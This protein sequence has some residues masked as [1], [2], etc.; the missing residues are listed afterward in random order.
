MGNKVTYTSEDHL[1]T[2]QARAEEAFLA[3]F[4]KGDYTIDNPYV[5]EN[6]YLINPLCAMVLFTTAE[7]VAPTITVC[8]KRFSRENLSHTFAPAKEH[9]LPVLGLYEDFVNK[10]VISLP[11]GTETTVTITTGK[12]P[13]AVCRCRNITTSADYL[14]D[15]FMFLTPAGKN[16]PTAYD[17]KGNVRWLLTENTMFDIKRAANGNLLT[18]SSR[19]CRM[20]YNATGLIELDMLGKLYKEYRLPGNYHH[21]QFEMEDGNLLILTQDFHTDTVEDMC[22]LVDRNSGEILKTWDYK[23]V[24][25]QDVAGSGS[26]DAPDWFHNNAV[27]YDK[28]TNSLSLSG[29]HQD[30]IINLDF[31][32]GK[33]NWIVGDPEGWPQELVDKYF[34]TPVGD[35]DN[36]DWQYEQHAC[37]IT[38][39]GDVMCFD[40]GQYRAKSK[41]NYIKNSENFSRGVRYRIDTEKMEIEQVWQYGKERGQDFFSP[42]ICNVEYYADGHYMT[43]SGGIGLKDGNAADGL[44]AFLDTN[45][46][47]VELRSITVEEK[48]GVVLYELETEGNFYRAEKLPIYHDGDNVTLGAGQLL[49]SLDV[50]PEFDT[51]PDAEE[52]NEQPDSF[53]NI[54]IEEDEDRFVFHGKFERGTLAMLCVEGPEKCHN[55]YINTAAVHHLAMCSGAFLEDDDRDVKMNIS[56]IGLTKGKLAIKLIINDKKYDTGVSILI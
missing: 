32:S 21:D 47:T 28:L 19:F 26:Q 51:V 11:N 39:E 12:L 30:A 54:I 7:E 43:H 52:V 5:V 36:F 20:P 53:H 16:L 22:V 37:V 10:V 8:G 35:V 23:D 14:Q 27:W 17:Y 29:R 42:Y 55:Y 1:I 9:K 34:F 24:I 15:N 4:K 56:K 6:P 50:T 33:L 18:G 13:E 41:E 44:G 46:P 31:D 45:D 49:G 3:E 38:P 2:R 25:P 48:D 40:N